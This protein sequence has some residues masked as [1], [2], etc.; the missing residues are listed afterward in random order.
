[1]SVTSDKNKL[2]HK[3]EGILNIVFNPH[4]SILNALKHFYWM[5]FFNTEKDFLSLAF[6]HIQKSVSLRR[7]GKMS[8]LYKINFYSIMIICMY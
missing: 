5:T 7:Y 1:M 8:L 4:T 2:I 6:Y 3:Y